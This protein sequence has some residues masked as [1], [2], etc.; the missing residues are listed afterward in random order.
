MPDK[1]ALYLFLPM[2]T[3]FMAGTLIPVQAASGATLGRML[4]H[5][6]WGA[7][8][9]LSTGVVAILVVATLMRLPVPKFQSAVS[10]PWWMWIGGLTGAVYVATSL[11]LLPKV[12]ASGFLLCVIAGQMI[13]AMLLDH[14]GLLGLTAKPVSFGRLLGVGILLFGLVVAQFS[15]SGVSQAVSNDKEVLTEQASNRNTL[16]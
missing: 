6:L 13:A 1:T 7:A 3:A 4:G 9:A 5:P 16:N 8:V 2:L 10:G 15:N 14:F 12:G 11:A